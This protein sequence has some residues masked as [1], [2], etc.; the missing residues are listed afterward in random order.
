M[1]SNILKHLNTGKYVLNIACYN[2]NIN[3]VLDFHYI[4]NPMPG[5]P[6]YNYRYFIQTQQ[7]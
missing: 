2:K 7:L 6:H 3:I 4:I 5:A 1:R